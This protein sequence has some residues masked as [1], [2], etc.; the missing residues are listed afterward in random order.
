MAGTHRDVSLKQVFDRV[1]K[2]PDLHVATLNLYHYSETQ[3]AKG[4]AGLVPRLEKTHSALAEHLHQHAADEFR[5]AEMIGNLMAEFGA[6]PTPPVGVRYVDEFE[7]L[8][9]GVFE[10]AEPDEVEIMVGINVTE[11]RGLKSF[12]LHVAALPEDSSSFRTLNQIKAEEAGHVRWGNDSI[13]RFQTQGWGAKVAAAQ[14][15]FG[16]IE[17][18]AYRT[19]MD[20]LPFAPVRR[21]GHVLDIAGDLPAPKRFEYLWDHVAR[22]L[23][24]FPLAQARLEFVSS[25]ATTPSLREQLAEDVTA[26]WNQGTFNNDSVLG[27]LGQETWNEVRSW[28]D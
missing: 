12:A 3:G 15:R 27:R 4:I 19:S 18:A 11:K 28:F 8:A 1:A 24:P 20:L 17:Q 10:Q 13:R 5:H 23:D 2:N 16:K 25:L 7:A 21:L 6:H 14:S 9:K 26:F 22:V